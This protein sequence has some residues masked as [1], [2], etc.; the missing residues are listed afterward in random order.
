[1]TPILEPP[2]NA[3]RGTCNQI[4]MLLIMFLILSQDSSFNRKGGCGEVYKA[5]L[6][7]S[8]GK[9]IAI[10]NIIQPSK[11]ATELTEEDSKLLKKKMQ[12]I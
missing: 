1:M 10:K 9:M 7:G 3:S 4:Y 2:H 8:N 11:E 5:E 6:P 12:Q